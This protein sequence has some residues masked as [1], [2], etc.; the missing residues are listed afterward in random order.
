MDDIGNFVQRGLCRARN[1]KFNH[2]P[3]GSHGRA[4]LTG[5]REKDDKIVWVK[6]GEKSRYCMKLKVTAFVR[7]YLWVDN[8]LSDHCPIIVDF[9][10]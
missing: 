10:L 9:A 8:G 7:V 6:T 4:D 5:G 2:G 1:S 3:H